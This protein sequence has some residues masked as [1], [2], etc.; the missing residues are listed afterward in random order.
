[1]EDRDVAASRELVVLRPEPGYAVTPESFGD[2]RQGVRIVSVDETTGAVLIDAP[3]PDLPHLRAK[4][5]HYADDSRI[6]PRSGTR[7]G[8]QALAPLAGV[9]LAELEDL[10]GPRLR[11][12]LGLPVA[13]DDGSAAVATLGAAAVEAPPRLADH[14]L[15]W[16][17][18]S[19]R[20]GSREAWNVTER[21][22]AQVRRLF[23]RLDRRAPQMFVAAERLVLFGRLTLADLRTLL[24]ATDCV[25]E[26]DLAG[27][28]VRDW[29]LVSNQGSTAR[30]LRDV[31]LAPPLPDAPSVVALDTGVATRH[32]L[33]A[34][35][36]LS[37]DS[38]VTH[39]PS[40][41]D[42]DG[43]G[44]LM[45]GVALFEDV[46]RLVEQ[47]SGA[48]T[49]WLQSVKMLRQ[50]GDGS[51]AEENRTFWPVVTQD[52]VEQAE[53]EGGH[54]GQA[55][56]RV[57]AMAVTAP[58][59][60]PPAATI[61]SNALGQLAY[62]EGHGRLLVV[63]AGN[64]DVNDPRLAQAYPTLHLTQPLEDPAQA[65]NVLTV[66]AYTALDTLP[67]EEGYANMTCLAPAGGVSPWTRAGVPRAKLASKPD[68]VFEGGNATFDQSVGYSGC[69]TLCT[70]TTGKDWVR[71]PLDV[72]AMTSCATAHAARF[73]ARVWAARSD[74]RPET[75]RG[76]VVH[77][78]R[79][80]PRMV[81]QLPNLEE[82]MALCGYG[83]PDE[84]LATSCLRERT[85]VIVEDAMQNLVERPVE[86]APDQ[87]RQVREIKFFR[88]PL[89]DE[90]LLAEGEAVELRV[91]LSYF[92]EPSTIRRTERHGLDLAFDVQAA[93]ESEEEFRRR[94][95]KLLR[96]T[97]RRGA[98]GPPEE[99]VSPTAGAADEGEGDGGGVEDE[100]EAEEV[101]MSG[102]AE[103][104]LGA[105]NAR[106]ARRRAGWGNQWQIGIQRRARGTVQSDY[107]TVPAAL[108]AGAKL[109][110]VYPVLG[111][112]DDRRETELEE[113]SFS[114][115]VT[116]TAPGRD[117]YTPI[118]IALAAELAAE[119]AAT[120]TEI[121]VHDGP[122]E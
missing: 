1:M 13:P 73:A 111:W 74:L 22:Q 15:R 6:N 84:A 94:M 68:V 82:R 41:E 86:G 110:A 64:S 20:G 121:S 99:A 100:G 35:V 16:F 80:T 19:C 97:R 119:V 21:A 65:A 116:I 53:R 43:H 33:L 2:A 10:A 112:W 63:S 39:D 76:L 104:T 75:V 115:I 51:A 26:V 61:W 69:E 3:R 12:A 105:G 52:A 40:P 106:P 58:H 7:R 77:A 89:P 4:L 85:T 54:T 46:G 103:S 56:R 18:L 29:L 23:A 71:N 37:A 90:V 93:G 117:V 109:V 70:L 32:P 27:P 9:H 92:A 102:A 107:L 47:N 42:A 108:L 88:L 81:L 30:E 98:A 38:V 8:E 113:Q 91:T 55:R 44:T 59:D 118:Q 11:A 62:N 78:A 25:Y 120:V 60:A 48:A 24:A 45:A 14:E 28:P 66:G 95:N 36:L 5:G 31:A 57:F 79:W 67:P 122:Q 49:H 83:V 50:D 34:P 72:H 87:L 114:L 17:E 96:P 101:P